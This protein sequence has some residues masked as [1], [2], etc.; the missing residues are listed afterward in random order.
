MKHENY[1]ELHQCKKGYLYRISSRNLSIGAYDGKEGFV[2]IREKFGNRY[3][4]TEYHY[5]QGAPFGT[6][7]PLEE[8]GPLPDNLVICDWLTNPDTEDKLLKNTPLFDYLDAWMKQH[9]TQEIVKK[10]YPQACAKNISGEWIIISCPTCSGII[11]RGGET[12]EAAW[13]DAAKR[14]YQME[15]GAYI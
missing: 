4:F 1:I 2:G 14:I 5:D 12:E 3:L 9:I 6:V 8:I 15:S 7:F 11:G 10:R 13:A